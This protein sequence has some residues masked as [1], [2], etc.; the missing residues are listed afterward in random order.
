MK[1]VGLLVAIVAFSFTGLQKTK[2][3]EYV[4]TT[5]GDSIAG[6]LKPL[7]YGTEKKVQV[8]TAEKKKEVYSIFQVRRYRFRDEMYEPVKGPE[9]FA[10]MKLVKPGYLSLYNY[11]LPGQVTFE[12]TYLMRRDG[13][14]MDVPNISFKKSMKSF[15]KDCPTVVD[16]IDQGEFNRKDLNDII[17]AYNQCID[18]N[19]TNRVAAIATQEVQTKSLNAWDELENQV[20][21]AADFDGKPNALEM[22]Q[23]IKGKIERSEKIPNFLVDGLKSVLKDD[24]FQPALTN[25][26][27]EIQ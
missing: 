8:T 9:G 14:G 10:F 4:I 19:T 21:A 27:K 17:D 26:L 1:H 3:Q 6:Q 2:A 20:K 15:L 22:I 16:R 12:G 25:A 13:K 7:L 24:S 18:K 5:K 23:E 11:Q